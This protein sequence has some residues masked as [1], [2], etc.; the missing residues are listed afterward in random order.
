MRKTLTFFS[1]LICGCKQTNND[2]SERPSDLN[3]GIRTST[4]EDVGMNEKV[5]SEI[6]DSINTGFYPNRHS[7]LIYKNDKLVL[8]KYF[9]GRDE[10]AW[11]GD[12]GVI[13]HNVN[14]LHDL[15][16][17]SKSIVSSCIGI[18]ITKGEIKSV[19]QKVFD[20]F[21]E[22]EKF[23]IET[24]KDLTIEHL[25]TMSSGLEWNEDIPYDNPQNSEML[26]TA[27][28]DPLAYILSRPMTDLPGTTWK[29]NGGTTQ[30]LA[31]IIKRVSG[32]SVA[33][34]ANENIFKKLGITEYEW[35]Q[36]PGT[37]SPIAASGLRLRPRDILKFGILYQNNGQWKREQVASQLWV[38]KSFAS[39][40][41]RPE[42]GGY[43]YQFWVF[44]DTLQGKAMT[45]PAAVGNGDQRIFFDKKND[46]LVVMTAGNYNK[47]DIKNNSFSILK[48]IYES[49]PMK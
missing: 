37:D 32:K 8:E 25:L 21:P 30:L 38:D 26:M 4:L 34:F 47:W 24:K 33:E 17:I 28:K 45:W 29:Y 6:I 46:L 3:D 1:L 7:L 14:T 41:S 49:F 11:A 13:E 16:S 5:I 2:K 12:V 31:E 42:N 19:D 15:R 48:K 22:Y 44:N 10:K 36:F 23:N 27:S 20:F 43:G 18:A 39:K 40:V 35:V 9:K